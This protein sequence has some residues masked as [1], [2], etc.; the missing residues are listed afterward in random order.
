MEARRAL[1]GLLPVGSP[2][3]WHRCFATALV[4]RGREYSD[5]R[6][7]RQVGGVRGHLGR[8]RSLRKN[9]LNSRVFPPLN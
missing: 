9:R 8:L 3:Y 6:V 5:F 2:V 4:F 1:R 7:P